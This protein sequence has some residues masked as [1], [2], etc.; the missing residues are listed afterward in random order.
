[1]VQSESDI[2]HAYQD[3][4]DEFGEVQIGNLTYLSSIVLKEVDP[5]AYRCG[6]A[7]FSSALEEQ[8]DEED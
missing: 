8:Q 7:D 4:L 6:L 1:M 3:M 2:E 5:I